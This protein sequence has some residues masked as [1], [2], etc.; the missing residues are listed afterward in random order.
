MRRAVVDRERPPAIRRERAPRA[1]SEPHRG[2]SVHASEIDRVGRAGGLAHVVQE[3]HLA[4]GRKSPRPRKVEPAKLS[5]LVVRGGPAADARLRPLGERA[6]RGHPGPRHRGRRSTGIERYCAAG[7]PESRQRDLPMPLGLRP[8]TRSHARPATT[9]G[10]NTL[11]NSLVS[12]VFRPAASTTA[13]LPLSSYTTECSVKA[14][15]RPSGETRTSANQ[16]DVLTRTCP[17]GISRRSSPPMRLTTARVLPSGDQ[18]A[19]ET[20]SNRSRG[21][22]PELGTTASG[23]YPQSHPSACL[24]RASSPVRETDCRE[25]P[26]RPSER[27]VERSVRVSK[28]RGG[29]RPTRRCRARPCRPV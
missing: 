5:L 1:F 9:R 18:S 25:M 14:I 16:P 20:S 28:L 15:R 13:T 19:Q 21:A 2:R 22:L 7:L 11:A 10:P 4:V 27:V 26:G 6:G 29:L 3:Q 8:R 23:P 12:V 17:G 24:L